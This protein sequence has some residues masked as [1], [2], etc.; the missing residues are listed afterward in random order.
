VDQLAP[1]YRVLAPDLLGYGESGSWPA[2]HPFHFRQDVAFL[3][4]LLADETAPVH[5]VGHSY[6]GLLALQLA[7]HAPELVR[8]VAAYEPVAFSVLDPAGVTDAPNDLQWK[9]EPGADGVDEAWLRRFVDWWSGPGAWDRLGAATRG[10]F[11]AVG[12]KLYQEVLSLARDTT[13]AAEYAAI[14]VPVL[15]LAGA[16]SPPVEHR[17]IETLAAALPRALV[18]IFPGVGHMGPLSHMKL[19]NGAIEEH[20]QLA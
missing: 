19:V 10:G 2:G 13:S 9:W 4:S 15:L 14:R 16:T 12:W 7:L 5:V 11:L 6:G 1:R 17:I 8:S 20:L 18:R 3:Q